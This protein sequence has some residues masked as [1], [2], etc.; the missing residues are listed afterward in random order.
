M[1]V[2]WLQ[3]GL[4]DVDDALSYLNERNPRAATRIA[5]A[6]WHSSANLADNPQLG[7][8]GRVPATRELPIAGTHFIVVYRI[9]KTQ[10][11]V[12]AVLHDARDWP[13]DFTS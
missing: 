6:I 7:R 2:E 10:V 12:L 11:E 13:Q 8:T 9:T 1:R 3:S 5:R 4:T